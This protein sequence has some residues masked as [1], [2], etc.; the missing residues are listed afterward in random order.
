MVWLLCPLLVLGDRDASVHAALLFL[1]YCL[2]PCGQVWPTMTTSTTSA[3]EREG[4][5]E[6][7]LPLP[8]TDGNWE[9]YTSLQLTSYWPELNCLN[10]RT[11]SSYKGG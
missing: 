1:G 3:L 2:S 9:L 6:Q 8:S 11:T 10:H 4:E 5:K 7:S